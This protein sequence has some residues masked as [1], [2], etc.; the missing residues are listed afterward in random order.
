[1]RLAAIVV[2]VGLK[3][4]VSTSLFSDIVAD[5]ENWCPPRGKH[6]LFGDYHPNVTTRCCGYCDC[7]PDECSKYG[8]CCLSAYGNIDAARESKSKSL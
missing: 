3:I 5:H 1:M 2:L 8:S 7:D 6:C 4:V